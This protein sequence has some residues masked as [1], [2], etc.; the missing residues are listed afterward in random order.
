M[1]VTL[2]PIKQRG[3]FALPFEF[4]K[5]RL[6]GK[7]RMLRIG[8]GL[9]EGNW[10]LRL[11]LWSKGYRISKRR[12]VKASVLLYIIRR[13]VQYPYM[14]DITN[15]L[16]AATRWEWGEDNKP[17]FVM[18]YLSS[19]PGTVRVLVCRKDSLLK[20]TLAFFKKP[21]EA[22]FDFN[23]KNPPIVRLEDFKAVEDVIAVDDMIRGWDLQAY[24]I[25]DV[26]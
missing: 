16:Q 10:Y 3:K 20:E 2:R 13:D 1:S 11:D 22:M 17:H 8:G 25:V 15:V 18:Q 5:L 12:P 9:H 26:C 4:T 6:N 24:Q 14:V 7:N 21:I 19:V 23:F